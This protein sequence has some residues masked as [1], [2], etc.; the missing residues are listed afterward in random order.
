MLDLRRV[1]LLVPVLLRIEVA[2]NAFERL[3][4]LA[5][6]GKVVEKSEPRLN[7]ARD[8]VKVRE[9]TAAAG[10]NRARQALREAVAE[11]V[12]RG[13]EGVAAER[14]ESVWGCQRIQRKERRRLR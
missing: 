1:L 9:R 2:P 11:L 8:H 7:D 6:S 13:D 12:D 14:G 4:V 3:V 5:V 10:G